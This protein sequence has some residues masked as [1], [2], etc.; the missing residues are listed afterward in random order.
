MTTKGTVE[1]LTETFSL[2]MSRK[3]KSG[4]AEMHEHEK[5]EL[6]EELRLVIAKKIHASKFNPKE[7]LE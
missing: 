7:Y 4:Y 2:K 1:K 6:Q 3:M 5:Y